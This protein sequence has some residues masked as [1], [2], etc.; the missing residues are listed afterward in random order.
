MTCTQGGGRE[1]CFGQGGDTQAGWRSNDVQERVQL[2]RQMAGMLTPIIPTYLDLPRPLCMSQLLLD[3]SLSPYQPLYTCL[4]FQRHT[5]EYPG[6]LSGVAKPSP[7][8][9]PILRLRERFI[10]L[11]VSGPGYSPL[12]Y[13]IHFNTDTCPHPFE[14][15]RSP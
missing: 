12:S 2:P 9:K 15:L 8:Y 6:T 10:H 4:R 7:Y 3:L 13:T 1:G 5:Q 14:N 11:Y